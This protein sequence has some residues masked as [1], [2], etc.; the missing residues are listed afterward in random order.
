MLMIDSIYGQKAYVM[1][2]IGIYASFIMFIKCI[3][4]LIHHWNYF[5]F[6]RIGAKRFQIRKQAN[7]SEEGH[8]VKISILYIIKILDF[9]NR[10]QILNNDRIEIDKGKDVVKKN[11]K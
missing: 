9:N 10:E 1:M 11:Q 5:L 3:F 4:A 2:I 8:V 6:F 7:N